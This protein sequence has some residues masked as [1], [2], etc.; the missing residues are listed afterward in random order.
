MIAFGKPGTIDSVKQA[1]ISGLVTIL[2]NIEY[3]APSTIHS[4]INADYVRTMMSN[5]S[6][7]EAELDVQ[8]HDKSCNKL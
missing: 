2:C 8:T 3:S 4:K 6:K 1:S 7:N 5:D